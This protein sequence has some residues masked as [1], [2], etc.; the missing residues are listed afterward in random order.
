M[1][2]SDNNTCTAPPLHRPIPDVFGRAIPDW[3]RNEQDELLL[4]RDREAVIDHPI[5]QYFFGD[6]VDCPR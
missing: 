1:S 2:G 6:F 5:E 4:P 3:Y